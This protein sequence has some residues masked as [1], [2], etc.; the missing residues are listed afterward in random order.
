MGG[1]RPSAEGG[2]ARLTGSNGT[3]PRMAR[4][5]T[6]DDHGDEDE[7]EHG[8]K[9]TTGGV[10]LQVRSA[11]ALPRWLRGKV[12]LRGPWISNCNLA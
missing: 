8:E 10:N 3:V 12:G 9:M 1:L 6:D 4:I 2:R 5:E 11:W 7:A